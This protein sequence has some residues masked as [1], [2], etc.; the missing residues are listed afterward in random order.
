MATVHQSG[1]ECTTRNFKSVLPDN[2]GNRAS[3][4]GAHIEHSF[5]VNRHIAEAANRKQV[6][7]I[8][9]YLRQ[10]AMS[11]AATLKPAA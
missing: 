5:K 1:V 7:L 6:E 8:R 11:D 9:E 2:Y 10:K 3:A 4:L